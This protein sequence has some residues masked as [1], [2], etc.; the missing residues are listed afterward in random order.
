MADQPPEHLSWDEIARRLQE[1]FDNPKLRYSARRLWRYDPEL[2]AFVRDP[3]DLELEKIID[4]DC[5]VEDDH[6][7][8]PRPI[9]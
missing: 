2:Q 9:A 4:G 3:L 1:I 7:N 8:D 5:E 6:S